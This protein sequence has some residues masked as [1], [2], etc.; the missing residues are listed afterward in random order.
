M[1]VRNP[2]QVRLANGNQKMPKLCTK[3]VKEEQEDVRTY[4]NIDDNATNAKSEVDTSTSMDETVQAH[5]QVETEGELSKIDSIT[6]R[7]PNLK[8]YG[9]EVN[10]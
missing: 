8:I 2:K 5:V 1:G 10:D 3:E 7:F 6:C 9:K 4:T